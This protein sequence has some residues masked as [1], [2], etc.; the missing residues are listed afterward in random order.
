MRIEIG[1]NKS[2]LLVLIAVFMVLYLSVA[3]VEWQYVGSYTPASSKYQTDIAS[4]SPSSDAKSKTLSLDSTIAISSGLWGWGG[5]PRG[6][7]VSNGTLKYP[8]DYYT[9][10]F[11]LGYGKIESP[12]GKNNLQNL[13]K[14]TTGFA[15]GYATNNPGYNIYSLLSDGKSTYD[16][17]NNYPGYDPNYPYGYSGS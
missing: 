14:Y 1:R 8:E 2:I 5:T 17:W 10:H 11:N 6:F 15:T 16:P 4:T 13:S 9:S 7:S 3:A 12:Y